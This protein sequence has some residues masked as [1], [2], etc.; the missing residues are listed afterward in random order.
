MNVIG[1]DIARQCIAA[2]ELDEVLLILAPV[3]LGDGTR[4]FAE[5]GGRTVRLQ[6]RSTTAS[7]N[8]WFD[9]LR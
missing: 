1:A 2:G 7:T 8:Q 5:P 6:R 4:L 3:F 9:V